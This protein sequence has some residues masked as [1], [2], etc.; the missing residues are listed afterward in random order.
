MIKDADYL[1]SY[2]TDVAIKLFIANKKPIFQNGGLLGTSHKS[3][4]TCSLPLS[5]QSSKWKEHDKPIQ[6]LK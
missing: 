3:N 5:T 6:L 1:N 4:A 2:T